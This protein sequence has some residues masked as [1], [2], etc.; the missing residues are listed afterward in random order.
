MNQIAMQ[1]KSRET[2]QCK[3]P[4]AEVCAERSEASM[5]GVGEKEKSKVKAREETET[6]SLQG[7]GDYCKD[8]DF[9]S[10]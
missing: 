8:S 10:E 1:E 3:G 7:L 2:H 9:Y 4:E 5:P 6:R